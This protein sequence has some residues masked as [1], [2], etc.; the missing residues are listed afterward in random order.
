MGALVGMAGLVWIAIQF[1]FL[2][3]SACASD[4]GL[5]DH[6]VDALSKTIAPYA[7]LLARAVPGKPA[8]S[9]VSRSG[10]K[11]PACSLSLSGTLEGVKVGGKQ[12]PHARLDLVV[13][14]PEHLR[15]ELV[16]GTRKALIVRRGD[17][18]VLATPPDVS[19]PGATVSA[20]AASV[21]NA[22]A[23]EKR[24]VASQRHWKMV[25]LE[26]PVS[27]SKLAFA[28]L[29]FDVT[30][31]GVHKNPAGDSTASAK[32]LRV[33]DLK[34]GPE[35]QISAEKEAARGG[36]DP[37]LWA[38]RLWVTATFEPK[39]LLWMSRDA[40]WTLNI[41][42]VRFGGEP[43]KS[44]WELPLDWRGILPGEEAVPD[45]LGWAVDWVTY[46]ANGTGSS[47]PSP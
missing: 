6:P 30:D 36:S 45:L 20:V 43:P 47:R 32:G 33:L 35:W 44:A 15:L 27:S 18:V 17:V 26:L 4:D 34:P 21:W 1:V 25:P 13:R 12:L 2:S 9:G 24:G 29:L 22:G 5:T 38:A 41:D 10:E 11:N 16:A 28:A 42:A 23:A 46:S 19:A 40:H 8:K 14:P 7:R 3:A 31:R 37:D 39:R